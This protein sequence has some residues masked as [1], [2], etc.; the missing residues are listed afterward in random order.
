VTKQLQLVD[1]H[2]VEFNKGTA[3]FI[4]TA[5]QR[6]AVR[7]ARVFENGGFLECSRKIGI[8][9]SD[10]VTVKLCP[11]EF[12][13]ARGAMPTRFNDKVVVIGARIAK[14]CLHYAE[15]KGA[16]GRLFG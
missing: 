6:V 8:K 3:T 1:G 15:K 5:G 12:L 7:C 9:G 2:N 11:Q 10:A 13:P 16:T 14:D 4:S